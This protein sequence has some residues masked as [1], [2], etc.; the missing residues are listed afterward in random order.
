MQGF[1]T[2]VI[3]SESYPCT[4]D[5]EFS[6]VSGKSG[7]YVLKRDDNIQIICVLITGKPTLHLSCKNK[8]TLSLSVSMALVLV[9][10]F[11]VEKSRYS[12]GKKGK[13]MAS[14]P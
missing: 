5:R 3:F 8:E 14:P 2:H 12:F 1:H 10:S 6:S 13:K 11:V 9:Y 7:V 4:E